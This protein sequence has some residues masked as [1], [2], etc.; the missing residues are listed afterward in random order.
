MC[1]SHWRAFDLNAAAWGMDYAGTLISLLEAKVL[2]ARQ[3]KGPLMSLLLQEALL[4]ALKYPLSIWL[5]KLA[6]KDSNSDLNSLTEG[7]RIY[8][9]PGKM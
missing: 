9:L 5:K 7:T 4:V 2:N 8:S 1:S 3:P 6:L